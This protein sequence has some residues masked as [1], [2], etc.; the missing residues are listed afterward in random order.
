MRALRKFWAFAV[1][2]A[3]IVAGT[4]DAKEKPVAVKPGTGLAF[5]FFDFSE[6]EVGVD[7]V[8]L[9]RIKPAKFKI[10]GFGVQPWASGTITYTDGSFFSPNLKPGTY[11]VA[12]FRSGR[13]YVTFEDAIQ[14]NSFEVVP[15][16]VVYAGS[17]KTV[18]D[19]G[20]LFR[21]PKGSFERED[22]LADE[23]ALLRWLS[24]LLG[25]S[26]WST[27]VNTRLKQRLAPESGSPKSASLTAT[28][29]NFHSP[30]GTGLYPAP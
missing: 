10:I 6:S 5:G 15:G 20:G 1:G 2:F 24:D 28:W 16:E 12:G 26:G 21:R 3:L 9:I 25:D 27:P 7:A 13:T 4:A 14:S 19:N 17:Y 8:H 23:V 29:S 11:V 22:S 30:S 18:A